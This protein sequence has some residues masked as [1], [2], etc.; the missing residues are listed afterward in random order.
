M[1]GLLVLEGLDGSGKS[2]Q[3]ACLLERLRLQGYTS[4]GISFP[5]YKEESSALVR[6]YLDG[7]FCSYADSVNAYAASSFYAVDRYA[8]FKRHWQ[9]DYEA[10]TLIVAARYVTSNAIYQMA[11]LPKEEWEEYLSWLFD[12]EY[13]RLGLP[14]PDCVVFLDMPP[15]VSQ[16][17]LLKR[18]GGDESRKDVHERDEAYLLRCREAALFAANAL[19]WTVIS[20][21][22]DEQPRPVAQIHEDIFQVFRE[23]LESRE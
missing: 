1:R 18:Y 16:K 20:C 15:Q 22:K 17:L 21:A 12:Y 8:S 7:E 13:N 3:F 2:T 14:R 9:A 11:K 4:K 6:M 5:D 19:S 23:R 10:G